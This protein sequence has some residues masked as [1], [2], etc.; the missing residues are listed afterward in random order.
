MADVSSKSNQ[1]TPSNLVSSGARV[2]AGKGKISAPHNPHNRPGGPVTA[3]RK[4]KPAA[5]PNLGN[6]VVPNT[7]RPANG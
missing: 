4:H 1:T 2:A 5:H 7:K 3:T 6:F